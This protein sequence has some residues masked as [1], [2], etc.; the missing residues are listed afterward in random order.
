MLRTGGSVLLLLALLT[1]AHAAERGVTNQAEPTQPGTAGPRAVPRAPE[2]ISV[3]P[4]PEPEPLPPD[5]GWTAIDSLAIHAMIP[6][7]YRLAVK[8]DSATES[9]RDTLLPDFLTGS[10]RQAVGLAPTWLQDDLADNFRRMGA[11]L[12]DR[13]APVIINCPDK[14]YYDEVCFE[15]AHL[16]PATLLSLNPQL[17]VD[18]VQQA[19]Q[20]D[21]ELQYVDI[22]DY[23]DPLQGGN[24]YSTTR[25]RALVQGET[26]QVEIPRIVY[27]WWVIM[28]KGTDEQPQYV[29]GHFWREYLFYCCDSG[30]PLLRERLAN[31]RIL[32]NGERGWW[33][34]NGVPFDDTLP[35]VAVIGRWCAYTVPFPAQGN[36]PIQP[37][38]IAHE[39]D[40]NCGEMQDILWAAA[41]TALIPCG[42]VLDINEDHVWCEIWWQGEFYPWQVDLGGGPTNI[43][44]PGVAYDR[45]YGGS[46]ECS[47]VWD[48]RNDGWQRS[49]IGTYSDVCTLTVEVRDS[50]LRP[51]DG[52]IVKLSSEDWYGGMANCFFGV[53]GRDGRYTTTLGDW[54]NYYLTL[55]GP[56][57]GRS[58][59]RIIDSASAVPGT[60]FFYPCALSGRLDSLAILPDSGTPLEEYR[61][62]V[63]YSVGHEALY[64]YDCYNSS[65]SNEHAVTSEPGQVDFFMVRQS[66]FEKYLEAQP[67]RAFVN[68]ENEVS[69]NHSV[70]FSEPGNHYAVFSSEEQ[71]NITAFVDA[72]VRLY[73]RGVGLAEQPGA[74]LPSGWVKISRSPFRGRLEVRL[75]PRAP[76]AGIPS[77][78]RRPDGGFRGSP[79]FRASDARGATRVRIMD[80]CGR[81]VRTLP[82]P[83]GSPAV[84]F[85]DGRDEA[86][87]RMPAGVYLCQVTG[88]GESLSEPVVFLGDA[89]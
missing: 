11:A 57:G 74:G 84:V 78:A 54:Q 77:G 4:R 34:G 73:R 45:K 42:G 2:Q 1:A 16:S 86:G 49:V 55:S 5:T 67:F 72:T 81:L 70:V 69:A 22:V 68:D 47:G 41:R 85:W 15:V 51:V 60:H 25:Y 32:W 64:G 6:A 63:S 7:G 21:R 46:K 14:R 3:P 50:R 13:F 31:T 39:H 88:D 33:G 44:N 40:G 43:K 10:A 59:G 53:T 30:Y 9:L 24:Y 37:V 62:D 23:G 18:N 76:S 17:L 87:R 8:F 28:P 19:Y 27:Y 75:A 80:R 38:E 29:T 52:E 35:A 36:R 26:T 12:E 56:G 83:T 66:E 71:A 20:I 89:R 82:V 79:G 61:M 65:G 48:W 58:A